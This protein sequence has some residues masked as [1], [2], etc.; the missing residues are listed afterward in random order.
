[1]SLLSQTSTWPDLYFL[2]WAMP[3]SPAGE[4]LTRTSSAASAAVARHTRVR[5]G[6]RRQP[7]SLAD[8]GTATGS[9][10]RA[11]AWPGVETAPSLRAAAA[12]GTVAASSRPS[13]CEMWQIGGRWEARGEVSRQ[14][15][16]AAS[17]GSRQLAARRSWPPRSV[18]SQSWERELRAGW[19]ISIPSVLCVPSAPFVPFVPSAP[20]APAGAGRDRGP[21][22]GHRLTS[23]GRSGTSGPQRSGAAEPA[24]PWSQSSDGR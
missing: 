7:R 17:A 21:R 8:P 20:C 5:Q 24:P 2:R 6:Q 19:C 12:A 13:S 4:P 18:R 11:A 10:K 1:M 15:R 14:E 22:D 9:G 23:A 16:P 3:A